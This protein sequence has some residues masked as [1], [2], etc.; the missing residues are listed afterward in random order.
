V[1]AT[2]TEVAWLAG[3]W[4]GEGSIGLGTQT[5]RTWRGERVEGIPKGSLVI[6]VQ[7]S[8]TCERTILRA[9][10]VISA[11]GAKALGYSYREK[12]PDKHQDAFYLRVNRLLDA[13]AM[14]RAVEPFAVTKQ[15]HWRVLLRF[16]ALR[17]D[18]A[19]IDQLGRVSSRG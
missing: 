4:D 18:Q 12:K 10:E 17:L 6:R 8:M 19:T 7:L 2:A 13:Q 1:K 15:E 11:I 16:L 3:L 5:A 9:A 14:A